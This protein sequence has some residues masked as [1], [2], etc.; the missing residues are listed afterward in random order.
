MLPSFQVV[1][2]RRHVI[3]I[4]PRVDLGSNRVSNSWKT[5]EADISAAPVIRA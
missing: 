5:G 2:P 1:R 3:F 4:M